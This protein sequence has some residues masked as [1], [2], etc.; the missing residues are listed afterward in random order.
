M[1]RADVIGHCVFPYLF[2][3]GSWIH[4]QLVNMRRFRPIVLTHRTEN[5]DQ[6][7]L[8]PIY[9]FA[10][11]PLLRR[12]WFR[13]SRNGMPASWQQ[14]LYGISRKNRA[15]A[16]HAHF[17]DS[18]FDMLP[19]RQKLQIPLITS[20][21]GADISMLAQSPVWRDK[22]ARLF[23][24]GSCFLA[25]GPFMKQAVEDLGCPAEKVVVQHL[26]V[27]VAGI[28]FVPRK[29]GRQ[30]RVA[31]EVAGKS[32]WVPADTKRPDAVRIL[33]AG[34]FREKKGIPLALEAFAHVWKKHGHVQLTLM[35]DA[36]TQQRDQAEKE[37]IFKVID[38]HGCRD[39]V[40]WIGFQPYSLFREL[41]YAH[42][43][44]LSPSLTASDGDSEGGSPVSI[45]EALASGMPVISTKHA[46][47][48]EVVKHNVNGW[49]S[50]ERDLDGLT[51][52]LLDAV[53]HPEMWEEMGRRGRAWIEAEYDVKNQVRRLEDLYCR[54]LTPAG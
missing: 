30:E 37:R 6:F 34:T 21:Y 45:T 40:T 38:Q 26:G 8:E 39:A 53:T 44:F 28:P 22:Y 48:P 5:L 33:V 27:D 51:A 49:L 9:S 4:A 15:R 36:T 16:L 7:P 46:D 20:F 10:D 18:A 2:L 43:L 14:F 35:G 54:V 3:T 13:L 24:E 17:G 1:D 52:N 42:D 32:L 47:I 19:V 25:E 12:A 41:L 29:P 31:V 11:L 50:P 23:E